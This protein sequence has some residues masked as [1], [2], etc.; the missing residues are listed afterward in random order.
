M[1]KLDE[2]I[3]L[4]LRKNRKIIVHYD[5]LKN[6]FKVDNSKIKGIISRLMEKGF[7][8]EEET[9]SSHPVFKV[10]SSQ[11]FILNYL[12]KNRNREIPVSEIAKNSLLKRNTIS[13][14]IHELQ[15]KNLIE[16]CRR[17]LKRGRYTVIWLTGDII[18][19]KYRHKDELV[20]EE[21]IEEKFQKRL[22]KEPVI[23]DRNLNEDISYLSSNSYDHVE[24]FK[25]LLPLTHDIFTFVTGYLSPLMTQVG[26]LWESAELSTVDEHIISARME[27]IMIE[28]INQRNNIKGEVII[29]VSV[30]GE[31][32]TLSLLALELLFTDYSYY[33]INL[34]KPLPI[35]ALIR[36]LQ[37]K[38]T[39][40][41]I[42]L[43][44]TQ[45]IYRGTLKRDII[46]L[47]KEFGD[48]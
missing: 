24:F 31:F 25:N 20:E 23:I 40:K 34:A 15:L 32:H 8:T 39:P 1:L 37:E 26:N 5:E 41:W 3:I 38:G 19:E 10:V 21:F 6:E 42:F 14:A 46:L 9:E 13:N 44:I 11:D 17:P 43:S 45:S 12:R 2:K 18:T 4:S 29:L 35:K 47:R 16:I 7:I 36:Y 28:L 30:E 22:S 27:K 33:V 48:T